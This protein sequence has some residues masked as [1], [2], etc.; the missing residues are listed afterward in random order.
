MPQTST[1]R[2]V[3]H[4]LALLTAVATTSTALPAQESGIPVGSMAPAAM[5]ETLD[6]APVDLATYI[7]QG[8]PVVLEFWATWCPLCRQLEPAMQAARTKYDGQVTFVSVGVS[9]NQSPARQKAHAEA[10]KMGGEFV[11]DRHDAAQKAY[12]VPHTSFLVVI[13]RTGRIVYTGQGGTQDV[14]AA[15]RKGLL[16]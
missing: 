13:D 7:D 3:L 11:F 16:P 9:A 15:I 12:M 6:G 10:N 4:S 1:P 14:E 5:V 8:K 2:R